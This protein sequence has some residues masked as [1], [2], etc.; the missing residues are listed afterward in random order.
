MSDRP[1]KVRGQNRPFGPRASAIDA[2][3][4]YRGIPK[5]SEGLVKF[6][7]WSVIVF[8]VSDTNFVTV[9]FDA[10]LGSTF[11]EPPNSPKPPL[12]AP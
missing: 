5:F 2:C 10:R 9:C 7:D 11:G 6:R 1:P 8:F 3:A 12:G 4:Q